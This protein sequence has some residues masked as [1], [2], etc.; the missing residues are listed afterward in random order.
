MMLNKIILID[1]Y[2]FVFRAYHSLPALTNPQ[3]LPIGAVYGFVN[4]LAKILSEHKA[5]Y[6]SVIYDSG[7]KTFRNEIY[8]E[9]KANRPPAPEDLLPQFPIV[10]EAAEALEISSVELEGYEADDIIATLAH[11]SQEQGLYVEIIS[12]DKDLMQLVSDKIYMFDAIKNKYIYPKDVESKLGVKPSQVADYLALV[13][14][15]SDNIPGVP[16]IGPKGAVELM[17]QFSSLEQIIANADQITQ[18]R[19]RGMIEQNK[20]QALLSQ[21]LTKLDCDVPINSELARFIF[22]KPKQEK[23]GGFLHKNGFRSLIERLGKLYNFNIP[24]QKNT[25]AKLHKLTDIA[26]IRDFINSVRRTGMLAIDLYDGV[27][28]G[29]SAEI[30]RAFFIEISDNNLEQILTELQPVL[31]S[32]S[33]LKIGHNLKATKGLLARFGATELRPTD[34]IEIMYHA[35]G[36]GQDSYE[37]EKI[38]AK[39]FNDILDPAAQLYPAIKAE[40]LL[41]LHQ[42]LQQELFR[43]KSQNIYLN[44]ERPLID[45]LHK[46]EIYG[47]KV[48]T[49][50]LHG[51]S[52]EFQQNIDILSEDIHGI[53]GRDFNIGSPKQLGEILFE[54]MA[55]PGGKKSR[56]SGAYN[57]N[58]GVLEG[59]AVRGYEIADKVLRWRHLSKLK[60]TYTDALVQQI[61]PESKR[62]HTKYSMTSTSTGRL[63]SSEPNLQ[64]IPIRT[65]EGQKIRR[66]FE[67]EAGCK[68]V[69]FD[70]S[71]IELRLLAYMANIDSL[72]QALADGEDIHATTASHLFNTNTKDMDP[73][74]RRH[75]KAINFGII[76]GL[77]PF[78]LAKQIGVDF[79]TANL[80]IEN[81]FKHYPGIKEYME[82]CKE[83]ARKQGY[84]KTLFNRKCFIKEINNQNSAKRQFA[85]RAAINAPIQGTAAD[86]IKRAMVAVDRAY[87]EDGLDARIILTIH[88][89]LL[90]EAKD[91]DVERVISITKK[92]MESCVVDLCIPVTISIGDNW[93]EMNKI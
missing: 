63:S 84:V 46:I 52:R 22:N 55:I 20:E 71:Q 37:F 32:S 62:I 64:N 80:Y 87:A 5:G 9:Y 85:E 79:H 30:G 70:Y 51:L 17:E 91:G 15:R 73:S 41:K 93:A 33:I 92:I 82:K 75:A 45:V 61:N 25:N 77:S 7:K 38:Y 24:H 16:G 90:I 59:L 36:S 53:A 83:M 54:E 66:A 74:I 60:N 39:Y 58:V 26:E 47:V 2:G 4:M 72:K 86:I 42:E 6:C 1:A 89:E 50:I 76:Y 35:L 78:G 10:R 12:S 65:P 28:I 68:L 69:S 43:Y 44:L 49:E 34:D 29:F 57:T 23:L 27:G 48:N 11:K 88:D 14:D 67:V 56:L 81:Y 31:A 3:G 13:G 18:K 21:K 19:R 8:K 40:S